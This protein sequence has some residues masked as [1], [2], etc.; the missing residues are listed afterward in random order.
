MRAQ[1]HAYST[2]SS[3]CAESQIDERLHCL[4]IDPTDRKLLDVKSF[5]H[6]YAAYGPIAS[7]VIYKAAPGVLTFEF[8]SIPYT[9]LDTYKYPWVD[10]PW[11]SSEG[12]GRTRMVSQ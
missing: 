3:H 11:Q 9:N 12:I 2:G 7:E 10:D 6:F 1:R 8:P 4:G 5:S